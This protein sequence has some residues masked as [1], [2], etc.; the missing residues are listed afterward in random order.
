MHWVC[1]FLLM[2]MVIAA[3]IEVLHDATRTDS[4]H[5]VVH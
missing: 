3:L 1:G 5:F 4:Y 2:T